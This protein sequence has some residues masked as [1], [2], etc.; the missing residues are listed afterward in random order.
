[1][2]LLIL[3]C[4]ATKRPDVR[5]LPAYQRYDGPAWRTLRA[6]LTSAG[7]TVGMLDVYALSAE[8]GLI[9]AIQPIPDY[10]RRMDAAR[11]EE[12]RPAVIATLG[13]LRSYKIT[14]ICGGLH[15]QAAL[16][17]LLP[18]A[19]GQVTRTHGGIGTQLGQ[20]KRWLNGA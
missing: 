12:L 19:C 20:L 3:A 13:R 6:Y 14:L 10:D 7:A 4:S 9:P 15:Y 1:M 2:R 16:P 17:D 11:A 18:R 5:L 8:F